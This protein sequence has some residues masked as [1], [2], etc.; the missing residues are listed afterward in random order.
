MGLPLTSCFALNISDS[1]CQEN[2]KQSQGGA[3]RGEIQEENS[4][5]EKETGK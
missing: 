5:K 3:V 1:W 2:E 4:E